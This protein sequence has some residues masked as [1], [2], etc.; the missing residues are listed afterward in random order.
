MK[1][2]TC[3]LLG[4]SWIKTAGNRPLYICTKCKKIESKCPDSV[5]LVKWV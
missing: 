3:K 5:R 1:N 2:W 4:H